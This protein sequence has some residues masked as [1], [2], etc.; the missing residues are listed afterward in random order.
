LPLE[1][2]LYG[3]A[4]KP[5]N[6]YTLQEDNT[7][8]VMT[9]DQMEDEIIGTELAPKLARKLDALLDECPYV[10]T[11]LLGIEN[12]FKINGDEKGARIVEQ[13]TLKLARHEA[14]TA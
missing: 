4:T 10:T 9:V 11:L 6:G 2:R 1:R 13:A 7:M 5:L 14:E 8:P 12:W 3:F